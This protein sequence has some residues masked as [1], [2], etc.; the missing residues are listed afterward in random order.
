MTFHDKLD[1]LVH[2]LLR[3]TRCSSIK[4]TETADT[5]SFR[6]LLNT[7]L[8]RIERVRSDQ[9]WGASRTTT[10]TP[11]PSALNLPFEY[12]LFVFDDKNKE[13]GSCSSSDES[14]QT[15]TV[16]N[17]LWEEARRSALNAE[18][19]IDFLLQEVASR[20]GA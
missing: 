20:V 18:Q 13:I 12:C 10:T 3:G 8:V 2:D 15:M 5:D 11:A 7:G 16:L 9:G 19:K 17:D 4:W 6:A 1:K 14:G